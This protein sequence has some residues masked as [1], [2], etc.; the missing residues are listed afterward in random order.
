MDRMLFREERLRRIMET[1][2]DKKSVVVS[3]LAKTYG[4]SAG[5]IRLDLAELEK[6]GLIS[7]THGGA[8][9]ADNSTE[10]LVL[11]KKLLELRVEANKEEKQRI[12][13]ATVDLIQDG[14]SIMIDGGTT[15]YLVAKNLH[16]KRGLTIITTSMHLFPVLWE[17]PDATIYLTGG[18]VHRGFE[19][20][21]GEIALE[22]ISKFKPDHTIIGIDGISVEH[23]LTTTEPL[24]AMIKRQMV[25]VSKDLIIVADSSK[26]GKVCLLSVTNVKNA[27]AIV[28]DDKL[29]EEVAEKIR[30]QGPQVICA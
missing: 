1:I 12:G 22:S 6:R 14:D 27:Q 24:M 26:F 4:K 30:R 17:I 29:S 2:Y 23:G 19:D 9:L 16:A 7:R 10:D 11:T 5:S 25:S 13:K 18:L 15:A 3:E 8:I 28:T 20:T 21:Y